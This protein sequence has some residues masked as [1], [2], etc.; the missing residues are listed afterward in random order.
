LNDYSGF[1]LN[2]KTAGKDARAPSSNYLITLLFLQMNTAVRLRVKDI[3]FHYNQII[4]RDGS[5]S[6]RTQ[7]ASGAGNISSLR[8]S[9]K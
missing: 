3:D 1:R 7:I 4:V 9:R 6:I 5:G 2:E 8:L